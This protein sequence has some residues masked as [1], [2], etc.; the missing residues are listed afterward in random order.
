MYK[1]IV[2]LAK[3]HKR[4]NYCIAGIDVN[5]GEWIRPVSDSLY[6]ERAVLVDDAKYKTGEEVEI[7]DVV[8]IKFLEY[9]PSEAQKE[10]Y[11]YDKDY[12][13]QKIGSM[14][15]ED[16]IDAWGYDESEYIFGNTNKFINSDLLD[17]KS[18]LLIK[19][20]EPEIF[21]HQF[22]EKR[23]PCFNFKYNGN[24]Y[25]YIQIG[26][27]SLYKEFSQ[28]NVGSYSLGRC[29]TAVFSLTDRYTD[30]RYYKMLATLF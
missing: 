4:N 8:R 17:G 28:K 23:K 6:L 16:V 30:G 27:I 1:E 11:L 10:N 12:C 5:T 18:L 9:I 25:R 7:L 26:D 2:V 22:P 24:N 13:W 19:V 29:A 15:I 21:V 14:N 3:S 20:D